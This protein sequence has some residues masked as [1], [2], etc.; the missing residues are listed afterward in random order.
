[1]PTDIYI[2]SKHDNLLEA[3]ESS[4]LNKNGLF[5]ARWEVLAFA[6]GLGYEREANGYEPPPQERGLKV[7][8]MPDSARGNNSRG[9]T[10]I[11]DV[12]AVLEAETGHGDEGFSGTD[13]RGLMEALSAKSHGDR[14]RNYNRYVHGGLDHIEHL[15]ET[16]NGKTY[17]DIIIELV[18]KI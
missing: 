1:M 10:L 15:R 3:L 9:D 6:A 11:A 16:S 2:D 8:K 12:I 7:V 5:S 13:K 17:E 14:C 18:E 4:E